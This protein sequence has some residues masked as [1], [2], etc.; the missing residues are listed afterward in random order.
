MIVRAATTDDIP[1]I[2]DVLEAS[3]ES[4]AWP[5]L[6]GWP[7]VEHL[8]ARARVPIALVDDVV[9]G[10]AGAIDVGRPDV[11]F[12]SDLFVR[13]DRQ[14]LGAGR[15]LLASAF[16]GTTERLTFSSADPR[17]L[18]V[19]IRAGM[20]PWWP[21]L[22][23]SVGRDVL[24]DVASMLGGSARVV[25]EAG[26][27]ATT[28]T[29]SLAWTGMDRTV[30]FAHYAGLPAGAGHLVRDAG[31]IAAV[32]WSNQTRSGAWRALDH[33]SIAPDTDPVRATLAI[34]SAA[35]AD[36]PGLVITI[37]GPHPAVPWLLEHGARISDRDQY[38][39][40]DPALLDPER[41]LPSPGFL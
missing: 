1:A 27:V 35:M 28:A 30:D 13:P 2:A 37:P 17:A 5:G 14:D 41:I 39:A 18:G 32:G 16:E 21:V 36:A 24:D 11:R 19:Y 4:A 10:M 33:V 3:D 7:Y 40:T 38:C 29:S 15:A 8:V 34:I 23:V 6:P 31:A 25:A 20:R 22:Y 9:V 12:L 26:D